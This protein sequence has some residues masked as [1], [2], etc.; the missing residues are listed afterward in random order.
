MDGNLT[1][2]VV[3]WPLCLPCQKTTVPGVSDLLALPMERERSPMIRSITG[4]GRRQV[5]WQDGTVTLELR[6]VNHRFLEIA[7]RLPKSL[8][9]LEDSLKKAVQ[10]R[11]IRGRIDITVSIQS[12]KGR[13]GSVILD[14]PLANQYH[15]AL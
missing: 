14:Q 9:H 2:F 8:S 6:S 4:F 1:T 3:A 12:G 13:A 10:Q 7:C 11:C 15:R 5:A